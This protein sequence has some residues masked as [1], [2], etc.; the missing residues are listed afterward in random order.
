MFYHMEAIKDVSTNVLEPVAEQVV[1]YI[2][3]EIGFFNTFKDNIMF[4]SPHETTSNT[5]DS[6]N[7]RKL[8]SNK[9]ICTVTNNL[10]PFETP[11]DG[12]NNTYITSFGFPPKRVWERYP[13]FS[14]IINKL[15]L[16]TMERPCSIAIECNFNFVDRS[17]AY[18]VGNRLFSQYTNG[19]TVPVMNVMFDYPIPEQ[20]LTNL[21]IM[22]KMTAFSENP[23]NKF[24]DY[25]IEG[26]KRA[27]TI[28]SNRYKKDLHQVV[29]QRTLHY[30]LVKIDFSD[31]TIN[32]D[33]KNKLPLK[34]NNQM[35]LTIQFMKPDDMIL[36]FPMIINNKL[37]PGNLI[38]DYG[39][40]PIPPWLTDTMI[41]VNK[42]NREE[43]RKRRESWLFKDRLN[44]IRVPIYDNWL[45][46]DYPKNPSDFY[47][48]FIII[49]FPIFIGEPWET[50]LE[51]FR[52]IQKLTG[53]S[54]EMITYILLNGD[55]IFYPGLNV[56][57]SVYRDNEMLDQ[58][59]L[60][61]EKGYTDPNKVREDGDYLVIKTDDPHKTHRLVIYTNMRTEDKRTVPNHTLTYFEI[62]AHNEYR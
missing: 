55:D 59:Q 5:Y 2:I 51:W 39:L 12:I 16:F 61:I 20:M 13:N 9:L 26:S 62:V 37:V 11:W 6:N 52:D 50:W 27:I 32:A 47:R 48:P 56:M 43:E 28:K 42:F 24:I 17:I 21:L 8:P 53:L 15:F 14:D 4:E 23:R 58:S 36:N 1:R 40:P 31:N 18:E 44:I 30:C 38:P 35:T 29:L 19:Q 3:S 49:A 57:V 54:N 10:S 46:P 33:K 34:F 45:P 25:L 7:N 22:Y 60:R 41:S